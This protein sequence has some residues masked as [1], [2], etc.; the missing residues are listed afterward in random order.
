MK[1][2]GVAQLLKRV[3]KE[4]QCKHCLCKQVTA[5]MAKCCKCGYECLAILG[6]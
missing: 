5:T 3:E 4:M 1:K 2:S 6:L